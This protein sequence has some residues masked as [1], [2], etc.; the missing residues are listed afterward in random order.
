VYSQ[1]IDGIDVSK[2]QGEID[3][4]QVKDS[5]NVFAY[6]RATEGLAN[7]DNTFQTNMT[8][9]LA[10]GMVMG[11]YCFG[12]PN[13]SATGSAQHFVDI[14]GSYIGQGYLPPVIDIETTEGMSYAAISK[15]VQDWI[16]EVENLTGTTSMIYTGGYFGADLNQSLNI[17]PLWI[18]HWGVTS[19]TILG[20]WDDW[21]FW[22]YT[23]SGT[24]AGISGNVHLNVFNGDSI[25]LDSLLNSGTAAIEAPIIAHDFTVFPNPSEGVFTVELNDLYMYDIQIFSAQGIKIDFDISFSSNS[26]A[27]IELLGV[28]GTFVIK[29]TDKQGNNMNK[30]ITLI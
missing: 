8:D 26:Q 1:T 19:P 4:V 7:T 15:W 29:V 23:G 10:A 14:A 28:A 12:R 20:I 24:V 13:V 2:W 9:G 22:Q 16:S 5:G 6:A 11:A 18:A 25:A 3:W 17:Y 27:R 21:L 30:L